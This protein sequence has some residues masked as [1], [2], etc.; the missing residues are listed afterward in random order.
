MINYPTP[1]SDWHPIDPN[2]EI[3]TDEGTEIR[4]YESSDGYKIDIATAYGNLVISAYDP[5]DEYVEEHGGMDD[6][7]VAIDDDRIARAK[8]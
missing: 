8:S 6:I 4:S 3:T 2:P 5:E 7:L 1:P